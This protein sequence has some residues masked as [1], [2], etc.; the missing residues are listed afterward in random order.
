MIALSRK[1]GGVQIVETIIRGNRFEQMTMS[2]ILVAG[3]ANSWYESGA[4]R[5]MLIADHVFI[6]C[7]GAGHP[8]IRIAPENEAGSGADPVHRNIRIEGN[9]FEGT[10]ALLLSVHG[11][12]GLVFQGNEVDV[13]GSR[14]GTLESLGLIT[15][16]TCRNV[17][18]SDNGL[19]YM[20][21]LDM[22]HRPD[23]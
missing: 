11:T 8:V 22:V 3:D 10:A 6:G 14:T 20:Q 7:G 19:F 9:R 2:A 18:I 4:V 16:E 21:D 12:E 13:T 17:D 5:N 23:G 1:K 15:V